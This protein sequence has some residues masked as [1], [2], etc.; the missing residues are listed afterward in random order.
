VEAVPG[1]G[2]AT[3]WAIPAEV[4]FREIDVLEG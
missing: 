2:R 3:W 4:I 1:P